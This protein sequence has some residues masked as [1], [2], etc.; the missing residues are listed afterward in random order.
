MLAQPPNSSMLQ[1]RV[2]VSFSGLKL[3]SDFTI[4]TWKWHRIV[5][6]GVVVLDCTLLQRHTNT[7]YIQCESK[8]SS[9]PLKL[10]AIFSLRLCISAK[11]RQYVASLHP[12]IFTNF[13]Q[14][15]LIFNKMAL[16][17]LGVFIVLTFQ[18]LSFIKSNCR[19]FIANDEWSPL[20]PTSIH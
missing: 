10:I 2:K 3:K 16:I 8:K 17:I 14:F 11:F 13:G 20:Y 18:V 6:L 1:R 5:P 12:H 7:Y 4:M 9:L 19:D 15:T